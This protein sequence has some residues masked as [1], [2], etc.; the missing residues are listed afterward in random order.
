MHQPET[1]PC[2]TDPEPGEVERAINITL[3]GLSLRNRYHPQQSHHM[4]DAFA[5]HLLERMRAA[6][7]LNYTMAYM[8]A[9]QVLQHGSRI[10]ALPVSPSLEGMC[11]TLTMLHCYH[12]I[13]N[14]LRWVDLEPDDLDLTQSWVQD[15]TL[16]AGLD[17][18]VRTPVHFNLN[19]VLA[20]VTYAFH[21]R[22]WEALASRTPRAPR[23]LA[24]SAQRYWGEPVDDL[25][26][27]RLGEVSPRVAK[28][29][30]QWTSRITDQ[31]AG[32]E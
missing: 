27:A 20:E 28:L 12:A 4:V 31:L 9:D 2:L 26:E 11:Y 18:S 14:A 5:T 6:E 22:L 17:F 30:A 10:I 24:P 25:T 15:P 13:H 32:R 8:E 21:R 1:Y 19:P 7:R 29:T 16:S 23:P 3:A